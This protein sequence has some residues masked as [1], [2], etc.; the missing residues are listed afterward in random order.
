MNYDRMKTMKNQIGKLIE[1]ERV[2]AEI[3]LQELCRGLCSHTFLI[4]IEAGER[5]C[6][7]IL[8]DALLQ[9]AGVSADKM[10]YMV[11][12]E[13][14][15]WLLLR[16]ELFAAVEDGTCDTAEQL[17]E[18]YKRLT[19]KK[20]E[21]HYQIVLFAEAMLIY[22]TGKDKEHTLTK[23]QEAW[24]VTSDG[25]PLTEAGNVYMTLTEL[26]IAMMDARIREDLGRAEEAADGYER[27]L[28]YLE[29][30]VDEE[31]RV[32]LYPQ[33][34]YRLAKLYLN[35]GEKK[36][37]VE[38]AEKSVALLRIRGR[39][40]YL[41]QF[42]ELLELH[43]KRTDREKKILREIG[44]ALH[45]VYDKYEITEENWDWRLP[46][47]LTQVEIYRKLIRDRREAMDLTLEQLAENICDWGTISRIERGVR[48][49]KRRISRKLLERVGRTGDSVEMIRQVGQPELLDLA[50]RINVLLS[51]THGAEVE[52]LIEELETR[53]RKPNKFIKQYILHVKALAL[54]NQEKISIEEYTR[55]QEEA[56]FL[57][58]PHLN[59]ER[60]AKWSFSRCE[61][62]IIN[63]L[64]Y[65]YEKLGRTE[66]IIHMLRL[67][68][69]QLEENP[70]SAKR[71]V[72]GY[73]L[74]MRNLGNVL[75]N[76]GQYKEAMEAS[77]KAI[78]MGL[79]TGRGNILRIA[80]YDYGWDM[81][82]LW[83]SEKY[84]PETSLP[85]I[86]ANWALDLIFGNKENQEFDR[87]HLK[88]YYRIN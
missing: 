22:Q 28:A 15:E 82:Q 72:V 21:L 23:L 26:V 55:M 57:T 43:G 37:A 5:A 80:L 62:D 53:I 49:P 47:E 52:P 66:E 4:R 20:S 25:V 83:N 77:N 7:K 2:K 73:E 3:N 70:F 17:L 24:E 35:K 59:E 69:K 29:V 27:L 58:M 13:E 39:L 8:A 46:F 48:T 65:S 40:F 71:D 32:K 36:R 79:Q 18:E 68:Q 51:F 87:R 86:K 9:R 14:Q 12:P 41:R 38:L 45:W 60:M 1:Y 6:E 84:K 31:D 54:F 88:K 42:L 30:H 75:G 81:E 34:A 33:I 61:I 78:C 63:L 74:T 85:Y 11:S 19:E 56:L 64:S 76:A 44:E 16:E 50:V 10:V 67:V